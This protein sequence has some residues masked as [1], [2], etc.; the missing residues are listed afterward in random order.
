V[1]A[2]LNMGGP[3]RHCEVLG[4]GLRSHG[5]ETVL[6]AGE[7]DAGEVSLSANGGLDGVRT[8]QVPGL[9]RP[10]S[11]LA[12]LRAL[13]ALTAAMRRERPQIVHTHT[14]K[15][16]A[17]GRV[18]ARLAGVPVVV[19]TFHGHVLSEYFSPAFSRLVQVAERGLARITERVITLSPALRDELAGRFDVA[20]H[21]QIEVVPLGRDLTAFRAAK[22]GRLRA[23]L[24]LDARAFVVGGVGRQ[25]PIKDFPLLVRAFAALPVDSHLALVGDG[26]ERAAIEETARQAGVTDRVHFLGWRRDLPELLADFDVLALTSRNEGTPLAI[27]EAFGAGKPVVA[28]AVGGVADMFSPAPAAAPPGV[29]VP[30]CVELRAEGALVRPGDQVAFAGALRLLHDQ[31]ALRAAMREPA[32]AASR[33]YDAERLVEDMAALYRRLLQESAR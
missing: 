33:R 14:A 17:L 23:E 19:H 25:V 6:L 30:A 27:V 3:A 26:T 12:D 15:A 21:D 8:L 13:W 9:G 22:P 28:S 11:P 29:E 31:L 20:P 5:F 24:G 2:R 10:I 32:L 18:A 4:K 1:I 7:L 16:G